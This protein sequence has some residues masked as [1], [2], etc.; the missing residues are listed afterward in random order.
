[1]NKYIIFTILI[2]G[3]IFTSCKNVKIDDDYYYEETETVNG[4]KI[5]LKGKGYWDVCIDTMTSIDESHHAI[6]SAIGY[7][8]A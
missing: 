7:E 5:T 4:M 2:F 6:L 3:F 1:M 8:K